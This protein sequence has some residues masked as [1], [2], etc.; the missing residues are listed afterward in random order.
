[1]VG[2][3]S[4]T[5]KTLVN[6]ATWYPKKSMSA[7]ERLAYYA[8]RFPAVEADSTYY[9]PP[10]EQ[11]TSGWAERTPPGFRMNVKAYSLMT[12]HPPKHQQP[13]AGTPPRPA[14]ARG[15]DAHLPPPPP[16]ARRGGGGV[17]PLRR[18]PPPAAG[19]R[20]A[21]SRPPAVPGVVPP[22]AQQPPR[23]VPRSP[24]AG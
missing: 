5:D 21:R 18:P 14:V 17:A 19:A 1:R 20:P 10:S 3:C 22:Q 11:L 9:R 16:P 7:A 15:E 4:W 2:T 23:A 13:V 8:A 6:E 24:T 12:G